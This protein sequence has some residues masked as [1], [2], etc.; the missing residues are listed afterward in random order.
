M[1][2]KEVDAAP[3]RAEVPVDYVTGRS[4]NPPITCL[5]AHPRAPEAVET[6]H[7]PIQA[8]PRFYNAKQPTSLRGNQIKCF[9]LSRIFPGQD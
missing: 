4:S 3:N 9:C 8:S 2:K 7:T 1:M 5:S 6:V